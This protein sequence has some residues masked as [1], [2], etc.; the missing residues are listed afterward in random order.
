MLFYVIFFSK[1][2]SCQNGLI[3]HICQALSEHTRL[4][5]NT[6][7]ELIKLLEALAT[8]SITSYEL[9]QIFLLL[10]EDG[11]EKV[12]HIHHILGNS[13]EFNNYYII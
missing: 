9:K 4:S 10:R 5:N 2:L 7:N 12:S 1:M 13:H 3:F 8:H 11:P 6:A